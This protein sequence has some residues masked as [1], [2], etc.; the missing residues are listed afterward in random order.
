MAA[1]YNRVFNGRS[2]IWI[3]VKLNQ[4]I[5]SRPTIFRLISALIELD[6]AKFGNAID[7]ILLESDFEQLRNEK[8]SLREE[9]N[10][11]KKRLEDRKPMLGKMKEG[12]VAKVNNHPFRRFC[13]I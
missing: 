8:T 2:Y 9:R 13:L 12:L 10:K 1:Y 6:R 11:I 7:K 5:G 4:V 3:F